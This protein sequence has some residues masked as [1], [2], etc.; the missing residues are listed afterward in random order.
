MK[1]VYADFQTPVQMRIRNEVASSPTHDGRTPL[2]EPSELIDE[3][4]ERMQGILDND[5]VL[6]LPDG[7]YA[8]GQLVLGDRGA[9]VGQS[10]Q[11]TIL[12]AKDGLNDD[13]VRTLGQPELAGSNKRWSEEGV[14]HRCAVSHL[15]IDGNRE[16]NESGDAISL[17]CRQPIVE[18]V[19]LTQLA[20]AGVRYEIGPHGTPPPS[21]WGSRGTQVV[22]HFDQI[23]VFVAGEGIVMEKGYDTIMNDLKISSC[24]G[25]GLWFKKGSGAF[26]VHAHVWSCGQDMR[27]ASV[28][29]DGGG[30]F[31]FLEL[32]SC[33]GRG[34]EVNVADVT[35][36]HLKLIGCNKHFGDESIWVDASLFKVG[37]LNGNILSGKTG[38]RFTRKA[39]RANI[40]V[41]L[42]GTPDKTCK[43][44]HSE[45]FQNRIHGSLY[46]ADVACELGTAAQAV[47]ANDIDLCVDTSKVGLKANL[48][49]GNSIELKTDHPG[50]PTGIILKGGTD[51][52]NT[53]TAREF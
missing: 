15:T 28:V 7:V 5:R 18:D 35:V 17:Y 25:P 45:A 9:I 8:V 14:P 38:I 13:L 51:D 24:L 26:R 46:H 44:I 37:M 39:T 30:H 3:R 12:W 42:H 34:M 31:H 2:P 40:N 36:S 47:S 52:S 50:V 33:Y 43:L 21:G 48:Y 11:R 4:T 32:D 49:K 22:G 10:T 27:S 20:G 41:A 16:N 29:L 23:Q 53:I 19:F 6:Y 1:T